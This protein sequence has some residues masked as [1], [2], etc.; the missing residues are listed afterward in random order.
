MSN[1]FQLGLLVAFGTGIVF[2]FVT[3]FEGTL[4]DAMGGLNAAVLEHIFSGL[5]SIA[6]LAWLLTSKRIDLQLARPYLPV[7]ALLGIMV[8]IAVTGIAY[9]FPKIGF[10][11]GNFLMVLA[12]ISTAVVIDAVGF[13]DFEKIPITLPKVVGL[14]LMGLGAYFVLPK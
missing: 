1:G 7:A 4:G 12:Q 3:A 11:S 14:V 2:A 6:L 8:F 9:S 13:G 5:V 10:A